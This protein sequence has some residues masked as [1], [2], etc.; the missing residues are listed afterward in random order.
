MGKKLGFLE[1]V[2]QG[3]LVYRPDELFRLP[4]FAQHGHGSGR[5]LKAC[6]A[7]KQRGLAATGVPEQGGNAGTR[8]GQVNVQ[9]EPRKGTPEAGMDSGGHLRAPARAL[10]LSA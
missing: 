5:V 1:H 2:R 10:P 4:G 7:P 3:A 9:V 8:E 6:H